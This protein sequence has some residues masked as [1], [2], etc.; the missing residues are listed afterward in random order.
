MRR[1][2][3]V[4]G[5]VVALVLLLAVGVLG[6]ALARPYLAANTA[7][8]APQLDPRAEAFLATG[9]KAMADG[10]LDQA[11][12]ALDKAS[13]LAETDPR[14]RL[15]EA[16]VAAA[17][18]DVPWLKLKI[19]PATAV[20][21]MR[22]TKAEADERVGRASRLAD[23][24]LASSPDSAAAFRAK[25]DA[26][27]LA[28]QEDAARALVTKVIA[29]AAQP[30]TAYVLAALDLAEPDPLWTTLIDRLRLAAA[31][32]GNA[33]R[34]GG[35]G[36]RAGQVGRRR[37]RSSRARE[38]RCPRSTLSAL[39]GVACIDREDGSEGRGRCRSRRSAAG[40]GRCRRDIAGR[41]RCR[42][43]GGW[44]VAACRRDRRRR[45]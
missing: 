15:D 12:E 8:A 25:L 1:G 29:Q 10:N 27:R 42:P 9:E 41:T 5:W 36:V 22:M 43:A 45:G 11:Q 38:A 24:A 14:V 18:A 19:L 35:A 31:G 28:G 26:L 33:G 13:A 2:R 44:A 23:A 30:E 6:W 16:R 4:G 32:E 17:R 7:P 40:A 34:T 39:S 20:D 3:R 37:W 21:E